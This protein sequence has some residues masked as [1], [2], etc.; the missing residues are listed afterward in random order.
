MWVISWMH[1]CNWIFIRS[2]YL[3][4]DKVAAENGMISLFMKTLSDPSILKKL[5]SHKV[6]NRYL[7]NSEPTALLLADNY[8][9]IPTSNQDNSSYIS[10]WWAEYG[11]GKVQLFCGISSENVFKPNE[12]VYTSGSTAYPQLYK[13]CTSKIN[14]FL[15]LGNALAHANSTAYIHW[16]RWYYFHTNPEFLD[17]KI[18]FSR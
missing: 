1:G 12:S 8:V 15:N 2:L 16:S 3:W 13:R 5:E 17:S 10:N 7:L 14:Y 4:T 6:C 18:H 9:D 11:I